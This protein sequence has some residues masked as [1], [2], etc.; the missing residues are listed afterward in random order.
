MSR[1]P[2][3]EDEPVHMYTRVA[4]AVC[5]SMVVTLLVES[6]SAVD[7]DVVH[8]FEDPRQVLAR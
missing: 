2:Y 6:L 8:A 4:Q 5:S 3:T 1:Y 7:V